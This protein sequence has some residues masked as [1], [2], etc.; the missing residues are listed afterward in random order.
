M[1]LDSERVI[2]IKLGSSY[3][4]FLPSSQGSVLI[5]AGNHNKHNQLQSVLLAHEYDIRDI[6]YII[7]THTHHD[8]VG[9]L[10]EIKK[11]S[12]AKVFVHKEEATFLENGRT[13]LPNGTMLWT[14]TIVRI[15][16]MIRFGGYPPVTPDFII[17]D[18]LQLSEFDFSITILSTPGHTSGSMTIIVDDKY[19]FAG[20]TLFNIRPDTVFPP[21][22]ND[23]AA[24]LSSWN[25]LLDTPCDIFYPGHGRP[26]ERS[27]LE[28][29]YVKALNNAKK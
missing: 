3:C 27:K 22:A 23:E 20:D 14:K 8:H 12:G 28:R 21:F 19:A 18:Q 1:A 15:G 16:K 29:S 10:A 6:R 11:I 24:L 13:P 5:D 9:S 7:L 2:P 4:Y 17:A 26:I 25:R